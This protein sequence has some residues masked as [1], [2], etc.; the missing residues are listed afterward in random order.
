M[1]IVTLIIA[2]VIGAVSYSQSNSNKLIASC[3][4]ETGRCVGSSYCTTCKNCSRC[5]HCSKNGGS[6]G[7]CSTSNSRS[8][9]ATPKQNKK[10]R[11]SSKTYKNYT[12]TTELYI[13]I[14]ALNLRKGPGTKFKIIEKLDN[15]DKLFYLG[16]EKLWIKVKVEKSGAVGYVYYK[17]LKE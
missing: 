10:I 13:T 8:Y 12:L 11:N 17:Y 2:L 3:C 7:V 5:K 1:K 4:T 16:K 6:C 9:T 15:S 14:A